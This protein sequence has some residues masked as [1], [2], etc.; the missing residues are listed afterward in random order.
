MKKC[1]TVSASRLSQKL[2]LLSDTV[3]DCNRHCMN[4]VVRDDPGQ[5]RELLR[6]MDRCR[7]QLSGMDE[8]LSVI[9]GARDVIDLYGQ[10]DGTA[11][12]DRQSS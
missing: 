6:D 1:I 4:I 3:N 8:L 12:S 11:A 7:D 5:V 9:R 10:S 2:G